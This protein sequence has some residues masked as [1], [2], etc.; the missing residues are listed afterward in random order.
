M[1]ANRIPHEKLPCLK[2]CIRVLPCGHKCSGV[3]TDPC[4]CR[5]D[6]DQFKTLEAER[7]LAQLQLE[8]APSSS[9]TM[10]APAPDHVRDS[11]SEEWVEFSRNPQAHDEAIR[12]ARLQAME[13]L[14]K[15]DAP[16]A[17]PDQNNIK[18]HFIPISN[19]DGERVR[20]QP[21]ARGRG[22]PKASAQ[23]NNQNTGRR[24]NNGKQQGQDVRT[25]TQGRTPFKGKRVEAAS[26]FRNSGN[27]NARGNSQRNQTRGLP[28]RHQNRLDQRR[29]QQLLQPHISSISG[30][31]TVNKPLADLLHTV[32][33]ARGQA[34]VDSISLM[35]ESDLGFEAEVLGIRRGRHR[36]DHEPVNVNSNTAVDRVQAWLR[37]DVES[38]MSF[39]GDGAG[40]P[41]KR[42]PAPKDV[43]DEKEEGL[44]IDI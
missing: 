30:A 8:V 36:I 19:R 34:P 16:A 15:L 18:E 27:S 43:K 44:L 22:L 25:Q 29:Q 38:L 37:A 39:G 14:V 5:E 13:P 10:P 7:R 9:S 23:A 2:P 26:T 21:E 6:C 35:G 1:I 41:T 42:A 20:K 33:P 31:G 4:R 28:A 24:Y 12:N 40:S 11:S 32:A 17:P 3:C